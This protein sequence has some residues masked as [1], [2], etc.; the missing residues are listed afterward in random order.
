[1]D[2]GPGT[3]PPAD[4]PRRPNPGGQRP[5]RRNTALLADELPDAAFKPIEGDDKKIASAITK[6]N[7]AERNSQG[8]LFG[9]TDALPTNAA[10]ADEVQQVVGRDAL[11]L[12]DARP[13]ATPAVPPGFT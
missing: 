11:S 5:R 8:S 2:G 3:G 1:M 6:A 7:K 12:A 10:L 13:A 9:F 4:L